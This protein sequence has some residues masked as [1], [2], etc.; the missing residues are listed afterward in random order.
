MESWHQIEAVLHR[1][2]IN[3]QKSL[4]GAEVVIAHLFEGL[5]QGSL[6]PGRNTPPYR[7]VLLL[8]RSIENIEL[9]VVAIELNLFPVA[10]G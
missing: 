6:K 10:I 1:H 7:C 4:A 3:T 2:R 8:T 9:H 5:G